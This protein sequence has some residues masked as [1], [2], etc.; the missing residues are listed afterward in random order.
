MEVLEGQLHC[1]CGE[2][3][4]NDWKESEPEPREP[5]CSV[6]SI[7]TGLGCRHPGKLVNKAAV[8]ITFHSHSMRVVNL[9]PRSISNYGCRRK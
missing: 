8:F 4:R 6:R 1:N 5:N 9:A 7:T 3:A 2:R